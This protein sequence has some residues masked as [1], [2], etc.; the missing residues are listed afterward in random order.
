MHYKYTDPLIKALANYLF[1]QILEVVHVNSLK[2]LELIFLSFEATFLHS[3]YVMVPSKRKTLRSCV[4]K[5][6]IST[7]LLF[8]SQME[9]CIIQVSWK[10]YQLGCLS[11]YSTLFSYKK[12]PDS[13]VCEMKRLATFHKR[14]HLRYPA[15]LEN[16]RLDPKKQPCVHMLSA[17]MLTSAVGETL[18]LNT[19]RPM[20]NC[21]TFPITWP[22][23]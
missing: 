22:N 11:Y 20:K 21:F 18:V 6:P 5:C 12:R 4:R 14:V 17:A 23:G 8:I 2:S 9:H 15:L 10:I 13:V 16:N 3:R 7:R 1:S 19:F